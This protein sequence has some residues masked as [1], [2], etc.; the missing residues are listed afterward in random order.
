MAEPSCVLLV[1][2]DIVVIADEQA[3]HAEHD[4]V[5]QLCLSNASECHTLSK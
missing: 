1:I 3:V 4:I 2:V 5:L